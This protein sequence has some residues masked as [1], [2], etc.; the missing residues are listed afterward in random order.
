MLVRIECPTCQGALKIREG[1]EGKRIRCPQCQQAFQVPAGTDPS[2]NAKPSSPPTPVAKNS[3]SLPRQAIREEAPPPKP[4]AKLARESKA[5]RDSDGPRRSRYEDDEQPTR[6]PIKKEKKP[7][8]SA[9]NIGIGAGALFMIVVAVRVIFMFIG[10]PANNKVA[11][12]N[13]PKAVAPNTP[14]PN[15]VVPNAA[16]PNP[17]APG[18]ETVAFP[19][20]SPAKNIQPGIRFQ[21]AT[22]QR[23][24][25]PMRVWYYQPEKAVGKLPLVVV[26]PAGS[27]LFVGMDLGDGDRAEHYPYARAGFAVMSFEIDGAVP[28]LEKATD[29]VMLKGA[30]EFR[31]AQAGLANAKVALDYILAKSKTVDADRIY[32]AGH[33]SAAT[34]A[35]LVAAFEPRIK[36]CAAYAPV[37]D[38]EARLA[39]V[40]PALDR[41][42]PGFQT[43]LQFSSPKTHIDKL[44]CPVFLFY[45]TD[46]GNVPPQHS[47]DFAANLKKTNPNVKLV[48]AQ[49]GGH[50]D[51]MIREGI[52]KGIA[53]LNVNMERPLPAPKNLDLCKV[54]Q[55]GAVYFKR[56]SSN[57]P[58]AR[59][60]QSCHDH[61]RARHVQ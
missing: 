59:S 29:A 12:N 38:V 2:V 7:F 33:S 18:A 60:R 10:G 28:D 9:A 54:S 57:L 14:A 31:D 56:E 23:G 39:K 21:E 17:S 8:F 30:R 44:K 58:A 61:N 34:L 25:I 36:A 16:V 24:A 6:R 45:A 26:P 1:L 27:T 43:F 15:A 47:I 41:A 19:E 4:P 52:P 13:A 37:T 53:W 50:Y 5:R 11:F 22:L 49:K 42:L 51:S 3:P 20:L 55:I 48:S 40:T 46:D 35:L 32:I